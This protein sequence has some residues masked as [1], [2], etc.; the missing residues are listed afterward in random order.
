MRLARENSPSILLGDFNFAHWGKEYA[1]MRASG[2]QDA[3][4]VAGGKS[5][6]TLPKRVGPWK[7][8][9]MIHRLI[10]WLP[11]IPILRVD[12]IWCSGELNSIDAWVG[13]DTG[14]DHLPVV[15]RLSLE[16]NSGIG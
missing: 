16:A 15:A 9:L 13:E 2:L 14:S 10:T 3:F 12:Y 4:T 6:F 5:G 11:L 1:Y 7:R 8:F